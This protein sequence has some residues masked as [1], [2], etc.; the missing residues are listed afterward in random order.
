[1]ILLMARETEGEFMVCQRSKLKANCV[2]S[3]SAAEESFLLADP[4]KEV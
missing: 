1:M 4:M 3:E 2:R